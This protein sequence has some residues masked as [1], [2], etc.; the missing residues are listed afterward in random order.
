M[1]SFFQATGGFLFILAVI[2]AGNG[3]FELQ[4]SGLLKTT[5]LAWLGSGIPQ[6]GLHP[7]VQSV[8]VQGLLVLG[9]LL[10]LVIL[11]T[12]EKSGSANAKGITINGQSAA[13]VGI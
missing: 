10:A 5:P 4:Q 2:F 1:R 8:S 13:G 12:G 9:A 7:S 3:V 11:A 6:L